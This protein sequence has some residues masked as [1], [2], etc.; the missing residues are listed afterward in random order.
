MFEF[1]STKTADGKV[2]HLVIQK[3]I[4]GID[5]AI[6]KLRDLKM[7]INGEI[8][9]AVE[10]EVEEE[11]SEKVVISLRE[12]LSKSGQTIDQKVQSIIKLVDEITQA[13]F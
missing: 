13:I 9:P 12:F 8:T 5:G 7:Q 3:S 10:P 4:E 2:K 6:E 1:G 11:G